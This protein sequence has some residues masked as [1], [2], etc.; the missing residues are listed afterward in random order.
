VSALRAGSGALLWTRAI[1]G[2]L[3]MPLAVGANTLFCASGAGTVRAL[4][5]R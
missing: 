4:R 1:D 3:A 2:E 5:I